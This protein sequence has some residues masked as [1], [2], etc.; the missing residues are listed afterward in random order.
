[1]KKKILILS[2]LIQS[3]IFHAPINAANNPLFSGAG[4]SIIAPTTITIPG[5]YRLSND[6]V[7]T[8]TI[9]ADDVVLDMNNKK[10]SGANINIFI[11]THNN[12]I[13]RD[14]II[15]GAT[16]SGLEADNC[17]N[18][19][20]LNV[21]F[22]SNNEGMLIQTSSQILIE[23]CNFLQNSSTAIP[24]RAAI[25]FVQTNNSLI[26]KCNFVRNTLPIL[27]FLNTS[28]NNQCTNL[29][30]NHNVNPAAFD[31]TCINLTS[32][33]NCL[34]EGC[35]IV[36]NNVTTNAFTGIQ[37]NTSNNDVIRSCFIVSNTGT[38]G[39]TGIQYVSGSSADGY[40]TNNIITNNSARGGNVTGI[41]VQA[42]CTLLIIDYNITVSNTATAIARGM[43]IASA[44]TA[45]RYNFLKNNFGPTSQG[46]LNV[47]PN[48]NNYFVGNESQG[49]GAVGGANN[50]VNVPGPTATFNPSTY[51]FAPA[52]PS[53][54][55]NISVTRP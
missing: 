22:E 39:A 15:S 27:I 44:D 52:T 7:G 12:I 54:F 23:D 53:R 2:L 50:F 19:D 6:I 37:V 33:D 45:V 13:I 32:A 48:Q 4:I 5:T 46:I 41:D 18:I 26:T 3:G 36:E 28:R 35:S 16:Q 14:G 29:N 51:V 21:D 24:A 20:I 25:R 9:S 42:T 55:H 34:I 30:I 10:M 8:I 40:I 17:T 43:N 49:H 11:N 31:L 47:T 38:S 1:M